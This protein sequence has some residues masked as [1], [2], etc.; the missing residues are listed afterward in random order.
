MKRLTD[1][2]ATSA[3]EWGVPL[4]VARVIFWMPIIGGLIMALARIDIRLY[5]FLLR[6]DGPVEWAQFNAFAIACVAGAGI[7]I[8]RFKAGYKWQGLL[9]VGFAL[10]M[11]FVSGEEIAWGQRLLGID[12]PPELVEIN[13]QNEITLHNIGEVLTVLNVVMMLAG[14]V[15]AIAYLLNKKLRLGRYWDR[16]D[17]LFVPP[18]FLASSFFFVFAYKFFRFTLWPDSGFTITKYGEWAELC[19]AFGIGAFIL[20]NYRRLS[21]AVAPVVWWQ[22]PLMLIQK[23]KLLIYGLFNRNSN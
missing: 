10:A 7:A 21:T 11:F 19:L 9:F 13:K 17:Y 1:L 22:R 16:A 14:G 18:F 15:G 2:I 3:E 5:R 12:T 20:L 6:D 8:R 4:R 23:V